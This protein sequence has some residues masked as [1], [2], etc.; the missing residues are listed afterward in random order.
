[1]ASDAFPARVV[2]GAEEL[3][4]MQDGDVL[5]ARATSPAFNAVLP[6]LGA[7]VTDTGGLLSHAAIVARE[8]RI[9][10]VVG[11]ADA[12]RRIPDGARVRVDGDL[13]EVSAVS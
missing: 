11:T 12:T 8:Y 9:P 5:V 2:H 4:H 3:S 1:V 7:V 13:G 10:A 6:F